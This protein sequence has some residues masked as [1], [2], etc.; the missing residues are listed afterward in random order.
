MSKKNSKTAAVA[1]VATATAISRKQALL[2]ELAALE[3]AEKAESEAKRAQLEQ[4]AKDAGYADLAA[5]YAYLGN[6][7]KKANGGT[8]VRL[9]TEQKA[10]M[11][12]LL[13]AGGMTASQ[14]ADKFGCSSVTVSLR[15]SELGLTHKREVA[16][17]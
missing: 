1:A 17:A 6:M 16:K 11:D 8:R 9:T 15:K 3:Q 4:V 10:E 7:F 2:A 5:L 12:S 14:I 13:K